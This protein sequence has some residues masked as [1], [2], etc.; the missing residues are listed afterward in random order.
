[1]TVDVNELGFFIVERIDV[2]PFDDD[3]KGA[4]VVAYGRRFDPKTGKIRNEQNIT[5]DC[6]SH[7]EVLIRVK[8]LM[9]HTAW[10][11]VA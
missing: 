1:M 10:W 4:Q 7:L 5:F 9:T 3:R 2:A 6:A 11:G 8:D